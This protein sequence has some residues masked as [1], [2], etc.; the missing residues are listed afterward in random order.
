VEPLEFLTASDL[1]L[2]IQVFRD[3]LLVHQRRI[4]E[5][6]VFPVP[7]ADTGTNMA[8]TIGS[9]AAAVNGTTDM[10]STAEAIEQGGLAGAR[11]VSGV[12]LSQLLR[13]FAL[14]VADREAI[15]ASA[16]AKALQAA[17]RAA[18][19]AV[20]RPVEGTILT[21]ADAV[22]QAAVAAVG[23]GLPL[24]GVVEVARAAAEDAIALT[25]HLLP[26]LR[27]AGVVDAGGSGFALLLD[28]LLN[29]IEGR[30]VPTPRTASPAPVLPALRQ[31]AA[32]G[33]RFEVTC[34]FEAPDGQIP[35][36]REQWAVLGDS[37]VTAGGG[38]AWLGHVHTDNPE[39]A[40]E[41]ARALGSPSWVRVTDLAVQHLTARRAEEPETDIPTKPVKTAVVTIAD[42]AGVRRLH[43]SLG[44]ARIVSGNEGASP[45][46]AEIV[47]AFE[48]APSHA[49]VA[50]TNGPEAL[51]ALERARALSAKEVWII[52]TQGI[53]EQLTALE[54]Y[55]PIIGP[56]ENIARMIR[57]ACGVRSGEIVP[58]AHD[59]TSRLI[60]V[61]TGNWL[62][63]TPAG[64]VATAENMAEAVEALLTNIVEDEDEVVTVLEGEGSSD[65]A[66]EG[67]LE[68][69]A[70]H[71]PGVGVRILEGGQPTSP[72]VGGVESDAG[73]ASHPWPPE[74]SRSLE[75]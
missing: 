68:W 52:P 35:A 25:P 31:A 9:V 63:M 55:D 45:L 12:I 73:G 69:L 41:V 10:R 59:E 62:V 7:D 27:A 30:P 48:A 26:P 66:T 21:V 23:R 2:A 3:A 11:G 75:S 36:L 33:P 20:F 13:V 17:S 16:F 28:A 50:L 14:A 60:P 42:G 74:A 43:A 5:L 44:V 29:V 32:G 70:R 18:R 6:N 53:V 34:R 4:N 54:A 72:Y 56:E 38:G 1:R 71:R 19:S 65:A 58:A 37:I 64:I 51:A 61:R 57:A 24:R 15:D 47:E 40:I 67:I 8:L 22:V 46:V 39:A 49:V